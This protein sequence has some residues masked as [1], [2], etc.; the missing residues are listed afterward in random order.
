MTQFDSTERLRTR[1]IG[2]LM[3]MSSVGKFNRGR[4]PWKKMAN[5][6]RFD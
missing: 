2:L 4:K 3:K 5:N 1:G 6:L